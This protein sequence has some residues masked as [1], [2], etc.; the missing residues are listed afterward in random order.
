MLLQLDLQFFAGEKTEKATPKKRLD[1]R[2]KGQ[3]LKSQDVTSAIVL[4]SIF[5]YLLFA[6]SS[7]RDRLLIFLRETFTHTIAVDTITIPSVMNLLK[8]TLIE[9]AVIL[10]PIMLI[11][12]VAAVAANFFQFG[13]LFTTET[14]KFDLKKIDPIKGFKRIFSIKAIIELI[15]SILKISFIGTVTTVIIML[16]L[17]DVL[18]LSFKTPGD[19][20]STIAK[21][22]A[23]MGIAASLVLAFI[24]ILDYFY[25]KFDYEKNLKMSKQD[26]KDEYK[27]VEGDPLIKSKIKQRQREMAMRRMMQE[28]PNADVVITNPTHYAIALKYDDITMDAPRVVAKGTDH[29]AQKIKLIAKENDVVMVENRPLARAMYDQVQIDQRIPD[30]FFKAVAEVLAY[31]YRIKRKI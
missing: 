19:T 12:M 18:S 31:V 24:S 16:N 14:L 5:T 29:V 30:E 25:Q 23:I 4:L 8:D 20:L 22:T 3:V 11:A 27:N 7:I 21:L 1:A 2:K 6:G 15:K 17:T 10:L 13:L 26:I 28:I 9:M